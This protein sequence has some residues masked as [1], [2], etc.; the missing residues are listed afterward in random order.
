MPDAPLRDTE[1]LSGLDRPEWLRQFAAITRANGHFQVLDTR[2]LAAYVDHGATLL[3][4]FETLE[5]IRALSERHEPLGWDFVRAD[6]WSH[7]AI[8]SDG[9]TWFRSQGVYDYVDTLID[10]A[11]FDDFER[12][13]VYGAGP[14]GYAAAAFSVAAPG[15]V[16]LAVQPQATLD[17]EIAGWDDRFVEMRRTDFTDRFGF[18]PRMA[19]GAEEGFLIYDPFE[20]LDAM[21]AAL[22]QSDQVARL[23]L[24]HMGDALQTDLMEMRLLTPLLRAAADGALDASLFHELLRARREHLPYLRRLLAKLTQDRRDGLARRLCANVTARLNAPRFARRLEALEE[25]ATA[26]KVGAD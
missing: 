24:R 13:V 18:A 4:T 10:E 15:S 6:G 9:D 11:F 22:F 8:I 5:G 23:K 17:P 16:I 21:H 7:L 1:L 14:C 25:A 26:E 3:V 2:H 20:R 19:E 12:V